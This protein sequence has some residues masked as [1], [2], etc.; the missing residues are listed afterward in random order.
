MPG[1]ATDAG[2]WVL[3]WLELEARGRKSDAVSVGEETQAVRGDEVRERPALPH[4]SMEPEA[5]IHRVNHP[6]AARVEFA[7]RRLRQRSLEIAR[8][9][10]TLHADPA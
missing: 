10:W 3:E 5:S 9:E 8:R 6:F 2:A 4:V 7:K 1:V